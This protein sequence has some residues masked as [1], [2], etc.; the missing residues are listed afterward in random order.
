MDEISNKTKPRHI[1][2]ALEKLPQGLNENYDRTIDRIKSRGS[3][4]WNLAR[5]VLLW[6]SNALEPLSIGA[7]QEAVAVELG[8]TSIGIRDLDDIESLISVC[9]GLV[10]LE[11]EKETSAPRLVRK[12][13]HDIFWASLPETSSARSKRARTRLPIQYSPC[14]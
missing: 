14:S 12:F 11:G 7:L 1:E 5:K 4:C 10:V 9:A 13:A 3:D 8:M 6:L 2:E